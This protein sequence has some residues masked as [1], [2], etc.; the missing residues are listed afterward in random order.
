MLFFIIL[1]AF[2][3]GKSWNQGKTSVSTF[4]CFHVSW[5]RLEKMS[6][7]QAKY[8]RFLT[9]SRNRLEDSIHLKGRDPWFPIDFLWIVRSRTLCIPY[10]RMYRI[11]RTICA[12]CLKSIVFCGF[13][14][15]LS[16]VVSGAFSWFHFYPSECIQSRWK[17][18]FRP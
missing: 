7:G 12:N 10:F 9:I 8:N 11:F 5:K 17:T 3:G 4:E 14:I 15:S 6:R 13:V 16:N 2:A 18:T 1:K